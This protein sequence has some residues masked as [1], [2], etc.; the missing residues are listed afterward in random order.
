[1]LNWRAKWTR[2]LAW[3]V[4]IA[5]M[6]TTHAITT[7]AGSIDFSNPVFD[8]NDILFIKHEYIRA[9]GHGDG[10]HMCDQYFGFNAEPGGG[11]YILKNAFSNNPTVVNVLEN[12][13]CT[14]GRYQGQKLEGGTFLSPDLSYDGTQILFAYTDA[15][16]SHVWNENTTYH[17]F[18]VNIDGTGLTQLTDGNYNDFDPCWLPD[19]KIAFISERRGGY[20]RCHGRS[21]PTYTLHTMNDDGSDIRCV[22]Y[23][24]TNEWGPS[25]DNN[26][27]IIWTRWDY[28]DRGD[29]Q[30]HSSWIANP[31]GSDPRPISS[32][33][34][35]YNENPK[36]HMSLR[37]IPDSNKYVAVA[38]PH[39]GQNYGSIIMIDPDIED[40]DNL[41]QITNIT[42]ECGYPESTVGTLTDLKYATPYPLSEEYF[43]CV[44]DPDANSHGVNKHYGLYVIDRQGNKKL[45]YD[46]PSISCL[47]PIPVRPR[48]VPNQIPVS[49]QVANPAD[50]IV[51]LVN[52]YDS[53]MPFP[54][55]TEI[56]ELRIIQIYP[57]TTPNA[58]VPNM[59]Y[60]GRK[61]GRGV[62]GTVPVE[63]DGSAK[64]YLPA[65][66]PVLFQAIG[67]DGTAIQTMRSDTFV[68][69]GQKY[70]SCQGCHEPRHRAPDN[71]E[72]VPLAM[73]REPSTIEP[74]TVPG[75][76]PMTFPRLIQPIID[77]KCV[78]CHGAG[79]TPDLR[80]GSGSG[81]SNSY[82]NLK[83]YVHVFPDI[84]WGAP[85]TVPGKFGSNASL[86][87][88]KLKGGMG[89]LTDEEL[90]RFVLWMDTGVAPFYGVY[91]NTS[92]QE[93]GDQVEP[94]LE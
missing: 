76:R 18:K 79:K 32:N 30:M 68:I 71:P 66:I 65:N 52:V 55:G 1:M 21:V 4:V 93:N 57:K 44:Y 90:H 50:G 67:A 89:N 87:Y 17:I 85:R 3:V 34:S 33:Y 41:S 42:T 24:E 28:I 54:E 58:D 45:L 86:L 84:Q 13:I 20:G 78:S 23:H 31:D 14:N 8:F 12:S 59:S 7:R 26:G 2:P 29:T 81:W 63:A 72:S 92:G 51:N 27:M 19:G 80:P 38:A 77:S 22:S 62:L 82:K 74:E 9:L 40:D 88:T 39:H 11:L 15:N 73:R 70:L 46:D 94:I 25:V 47:D 60:I 69:G 10:C 53:L 36:M 5:V 6:I 16:Q 61:N 75:A 49:S 83:N 56:K 48:P 91:H 37:A 64:F 43:L 35:N